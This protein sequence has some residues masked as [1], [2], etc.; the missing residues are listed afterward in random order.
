MDGISRYADDPA[1]LCAVAA[2]GGAAALMPLLGHSFGWVQK[3]AAHAIGRMT[4]DCPEAQ[5]AV[6]AAG[7]VPV[8]VRLVTSSKDAAVQSAAAEALLHL[9][10]C[11]LPYLLQTADSI[12]SL[13]RILHNSACDGRDAVGLLAQIWR[14]GSERERQAIVA[15]GTE[16]ALEGYLATHSQNASHEA[17]VQQAAHLVYQLKHLPAE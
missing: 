2:E 10:E 6:E 1:A 8:L 16:A 12:P 3:V 17:F 13:V 9:R 11:C 5:Q 7:A 14:D 4:M 15:A